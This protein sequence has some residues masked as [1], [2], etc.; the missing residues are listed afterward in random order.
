MELERLKD[1]LVA[2]SGSPKDRDRMDV[3]IP[4]MLASYRR[5]GEAAE[6][7]VERLT[8]ERDR[9]REERDAE[10]EVDVEQAAEIARLKSRLAAVEQERDQCAVFKDQW[11]AKYNTAAGAA[12]KMHA[13]NV[14]LSERLD[15]IQR[16]F[17]RLSKERGGL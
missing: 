6:A 14:M 15:S 17:I 12:R 8:R 5:R 16:E 7:D 11:F 10:R 13:E 2:A 9:L 3:V 4:L 1:A